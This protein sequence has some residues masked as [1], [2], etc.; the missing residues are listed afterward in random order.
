[1]MSNTTTPWTICVN[2]QL[3]SAAISRRPERECR[4]NVAL[5]WLT[6]RLLPTR[7]REAGIPLTRSTN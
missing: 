2:A 7:H 5:V 3:K 6:G 1:M 4:R